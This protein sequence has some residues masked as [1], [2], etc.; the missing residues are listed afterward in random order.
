MTRSAYYDPEFRQKLGFDAA[1][2]GCISGNGSGNGCG[3]V[4]ARAD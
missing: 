4:E 1:A 3:V 2:P